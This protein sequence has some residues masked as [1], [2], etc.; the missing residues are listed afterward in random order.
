MTKIRLLVLLAVVALVLFPAIASAQQ[1]PE[2][3]CGFYGTVT[4]DG[5]D[6]PEGTVISALIDGNVTATTTTTSESRY[7]L[8]IAQPEGAN[9]AGKTV[10]F[11]I[12]DRT[13]DQTSTWEAG[14]NKNVDLTVGVGP[15]DG[16]GGAIREVRVTALPAGGTPTVS[17]NATTGVL[18]LGI[19]AGATGPAGPTGPMGPEG[20]AGKD[21]SNV[22]G[23]VAIVI[24]AIALIVAVVVMLRKQTAK[25]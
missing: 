2:L 10:T 25:V 12:G 17:W 18:T 20:P 13:A 3:P 5:A 4:V 1:P 24:A 9:N 11:M 22:L 19:P 6:A 16:Q 15:T 14:A 8:I 21:A 7:S 23:I